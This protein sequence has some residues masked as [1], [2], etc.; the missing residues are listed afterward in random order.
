MVVTHGSMCRQIPVTGQL[1]RSGWLVLR[2]WEHD[3]LGNVE[4][5]ANRIEAAVLSRRPGGE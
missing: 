2:V 3:V 1:R 5:V 4:R